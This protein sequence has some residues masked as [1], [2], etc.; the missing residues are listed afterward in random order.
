M[1]HFFSQKKIK[2]L[3][4]RVEYFLLEFARIALPL[5]PRKALVLLAKLLAKIGFA[6]DKRGRR[7][8][9][10]N[11]A[12]CFPESQQS[13]R[14]KTALTSYQSMAQ[15]MLDLFWL[16]KKLNKDNLSDFVEFVWQD[17]QTKDLI[18]EKNCIFI[19]PHYGNF[20]ANSLIWGHLGKT[21]MIIAQNFKNPLLTPVFQKIRNSSGQQIIPQ[22]KSMLRLL[23]QLQRG[24]HVAFLSD[25]GIPPSQAAVPIRVFGRWISAPALP[26]ILAQRSNCAIIP[27]LSLPKKDGSS[28]VTILTPLLPKEG[29]SAQEL[30]QRAWDC[31]VPALEEHPEFWLWAYKHWRYLP[32]NPDVAYPCYANPSKA[33][34]KLLQKHQ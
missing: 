27:V 31:F 15:T 10:E 4:Y 14:N 6:V 16:P 22:E 12:I 33:F 29:E 13:W 32:Q 3:R 18:E 1:V 34:E 19:T 24:G 21:M 17:P 7:T 28:K 26:A 2:K 5:V 25:L 9:L 11:L 30:V 8:A 20:E 23:R